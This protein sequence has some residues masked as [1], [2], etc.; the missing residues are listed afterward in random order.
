MLTLLFI[1][2]ATITQGRAQIRGISLFGLE[3]DHVGFMC[4]WANPV[5]YYVHKIQELGFNYLRIPFSYEYVLQGDLRELDHIVL[6]ARKQQLSIILDFHR[7][8]NDRQAPTPF[9]DNLST[10]DF[11]D[12]WLT[13]AFRYNKF[14]NVQFLDIYNEY[15]PEDP[16]PL[17]EYTLD[18]IQRID[19]ALP[20]RYKFL[21]SGTS[22]S[23]DFS[24]VNYEDNSLAEQIYYSVH[25]YPFSYKSENR[26]EWNHSFGKV[27][28]PVERVIIGEWGWAK[29]DERWA[30]DFAAYL[31]KKRIVN[32]VF[33][34]LSQ[35]NDTYNL[36]ADDC[37]TFHDD[38][39]RI[40]Q[41][42]W[43][44]EDDDG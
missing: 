19:F 15:V 4:D 33:W 29:Q 34:S 25:K 12:A 13:L 16:G 35:S 5:D 24:S 42:V 44:F 17:K 2:L 10:T 32:T 22:W 27:G 18:I 23:S 36:Y 7:V 30:T 40:I 21:V 41:S 31:Q 9:S 3:T 1:L 28:L 43:G 14:D 26:K 20:G 37:V 6:L 8:W 39:F 11:Q 38:A